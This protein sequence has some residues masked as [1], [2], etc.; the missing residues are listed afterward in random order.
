MLNEFVISFILVRFG[1]DF[2]NYYIVGIVL[3]YLEEV[4][5]K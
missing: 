4:E 3:V 2:C 5:F 1:E